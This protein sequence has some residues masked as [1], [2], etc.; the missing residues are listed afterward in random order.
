MIVLHGIRK[1][2]GKQV[3]WTGLIFEVREERAVA[4]LAHGNRQER[5]AQTHHRLI[6]PD[7]GDGH[8]G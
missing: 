8:R 5:A 6:R 2:F 4:L 3:C 7:G 1:K